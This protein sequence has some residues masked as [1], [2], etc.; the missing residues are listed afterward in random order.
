VVASPRARSPGRLEVP[1][2]IKR[3]ATLIG[4]DAALGAV[5]VVG[6]EVN[7]VGSRAFGLPGMKAGQHELFT[8]VVPRTGATSRAHVTTSSTRIN[9]RSTEDHVGGTLGNTQQQLVE[10]LGVGEVVPRA[11]QVKRLQE[12]GDVS[13]A[14]YLCANPP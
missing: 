5:G 1:R 14:N 10:V 2:G 8:V 9:S 11:K 6:A 7:L 4:V 13:R 3:S 12:A